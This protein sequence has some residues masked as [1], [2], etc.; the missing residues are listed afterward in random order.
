MREGECAR[1]SEAKSEMQ[2]LEPIVCV[3]VTRTIRIVRI[4]TV[5]VN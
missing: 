5:K 1:I 3:T 2:R 4:A